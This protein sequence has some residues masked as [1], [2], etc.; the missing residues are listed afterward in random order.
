MKKIFILI[1][2]LITWTVSLSAQKITREEANTIVQNY[3]ES[4]AI[5]LAG[6]LYA[7]LNDPTEEGIVITTFEGEEF[8]AKYA[9]WVYCLDEIEPTQRRYL[10]VKEE[11]GSLLEVIASN[12]ISEL[13]AS[14][15]SMDPPVDCSSPSHTILNEAIYQGESYS[16]YGFT[17]PAQNVP[18]VHTHELELVDAYGCDSLVTLHLTVY[19]DT[20]IDMVDSKG[21]SVK[22][23]YPNPVD[24]ILILP[25]GEDA[26]IEIYD[27]K[28]TRLFSGLLSGEDTCQL[29]VSFL[30]AGV[31]MV[32]VSGEM[33][34]MIK[35]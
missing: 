7:N 21:N 8:R 5:Q 16:K 11:A 19:M 14:W 24:D 29:N 31:Y 26:Y 27:L 3:I 2:V 35:K 15:E 30:N 4:E 9:C 34:K 6:A 23:L 10:F 32:N 13:D 20:S 22:L 18:G 33:Y 28:G 1:S 25:C 17:L 12:D